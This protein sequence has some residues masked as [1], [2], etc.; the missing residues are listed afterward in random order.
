MLCHNFATHLSMIK[1]WN[2]EGEIQIHIK[3]LIAKWRSSIPGIYSVLLIPT[4]RRDNCYRSCL[5]VCRR[6]TGQKAESA[7]LTSHD[8]RILPIHSPQSTFERRTYSY[9]RT[10][11]RSHICQQF[12]ILQYYNIYSLVHRVRCAYYKE[13]EL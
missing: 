5:A 10:I 13:R 7:G 6:V 1:L 4:V 12:R 8:P 11:L 9:H 2:K 3:L